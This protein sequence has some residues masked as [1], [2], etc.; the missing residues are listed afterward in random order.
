LERRHAGKLAFR[1]DATLHYE[2]F[3][4]LNALNEQPLE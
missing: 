3:K 2:E 4:V 1:T